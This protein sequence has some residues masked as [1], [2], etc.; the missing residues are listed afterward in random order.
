MSSQTVNIFSSNRAETKK[1]KE[2]LTTLIKETIKQK[3]SFGDFI[4][5]T[6]K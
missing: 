5:E 6:E 3:K 1:V 2:D 4:K